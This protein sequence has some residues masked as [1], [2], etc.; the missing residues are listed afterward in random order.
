MR[1]GPQ[2]NVLL[3]TILLCHCRLSSPATSIFRELD[4]LRSVFENYIVV[5]GDRVQMTRAS[6][7][8]ML[9]HR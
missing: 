9:T 3:N 8:P 4:D 5:N 6:E 1:K 7:S 2:Q